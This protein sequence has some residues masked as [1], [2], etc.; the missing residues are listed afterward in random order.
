MQLSANDP[1]VKKARQE[2]KTLLENFADWTSM[3]DMFDAADDLINDANN[4]R[5]FNRWVKN[6]DH[7]VRKCL[8]EDGYILK[9]ESIEEWNKLSE[10]GRYFLNDRYKEHSDR[11]RDEVNRWLG[12]MANDPDSIAFG[13]KLEK[14]FLDLGQDKNGNIRLKSHLLKDVTD[15]IIP[16]FLENLRYIPV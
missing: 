13:T 8:R 6:L 2:L 11:L 5:E 15:V 4:D 12:Y 9:D 3:D 10:Q 7:F 14:L 16:G 1:N